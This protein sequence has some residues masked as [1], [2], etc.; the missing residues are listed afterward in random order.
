MPFTFSHPAIVLPFS[1][2]PKNWISLTGLVVGSIIP[3]FE[4]F[5]K[6]A[7]HN[8]FSHTW[9]A[10]FWFNLPLAL[11]LCFVFHLIVRDTLIENLPFFLKQRFYRYTYFDWNYH[12]KKYFWVV[13][14][15][16]VV[17]TSSHIFWD[18]FTHARGFFV[19]NFDF[20]AGSIYLYKVKVPVYLIFDR[21]SSVIGML[22]IIL[23][24][25]KLPKDELYLSKNSIK[26]PYWYLFSF[27]TLSILGLRYV[28]E[29]NVFTLFEI[30][31]SIISSIMIS[32][33][34]TPLV[35]KTVLK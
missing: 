1:V 13:I 12:F 9:H 25:M 5:F 18:S 35:L 19:R 26:S 10:I 24:V 30:I 16:I 6:M 3:D 33:I 29:L 17:G 11:F 27:L 21:L 22:C 32:L 7:P 2:L 4:K 20:L 14:I 8:Y 31:I 28:L 34:V 15:S 23:T